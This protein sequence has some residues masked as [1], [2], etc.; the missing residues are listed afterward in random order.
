M[1]AKR[2]SRRAAALLCAAAL[3]VNLIG[4]IVLSVLIIFLL[5]LN[6]SCIM[7]LVA[8]VVNKALLRRQIPY[9]RR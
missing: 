7:I 1:R 5:G 6:V 4:S 9:M 2:A 3:L 8:A